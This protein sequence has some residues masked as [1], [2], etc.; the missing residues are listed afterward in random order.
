MKK[1]MLQDFSIEKHLD[2]II[3]FCAAGTAVVLGLVV[4]A[5]Y[6]IDLSSMNVV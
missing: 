4:K 3:Y 6:F 2:F 1:K 5:A